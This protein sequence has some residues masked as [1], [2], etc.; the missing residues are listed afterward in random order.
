ML[1]NQPDSS[2]S[3]KVTAASLSGLA[4]TIA[5][6]LITN[7]TDVQ[8]TPDISALIA[9]LFAGIGGYVVKERAGRIAR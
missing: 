9:S 5:I 8:I 4:S 7:Y 6:Y 2:P 1:V 3:R